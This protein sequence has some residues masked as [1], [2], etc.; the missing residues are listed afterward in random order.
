MKRTYEKPVVR[1]VA[2]R[3]RQQMLAGSDG[4]K[5]EIP[6][7]TKS[8]SGFSQDEGQSSSSRGGFIEDEE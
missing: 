4:F 3:H 2:L 5:G 6:G 8:S 7:Y 1:V